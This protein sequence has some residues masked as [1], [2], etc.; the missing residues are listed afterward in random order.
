MFT[1]TT[2]ALAI[3]IATATGSLAATKKH[4]NASAMSSYAYS[5]AWDQLRARNATQD[6]GE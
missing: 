5:D 6:F 2:I 1:R 4:V 3:I